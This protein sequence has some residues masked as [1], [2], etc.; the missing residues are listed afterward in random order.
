MR[1]TLI[2][3]C[4]VAATMAIAGSAGADV[5]SF[6]VNWGDIGAKTEAVVGI[7]VKVDSGS[8]SVQSITGAT[9]A[10]QNGGPWGLPIGWSQQTLMPTF[11][12]GTNPNASSSQY[13]FVRGG[14]GPTA[15][16]ADSYGGLG[17]DAPVGFTA[18]LA[19]DASYTPEVNDTI[20]TIWAFFRSNGA[21]SIQA[22]RTFTF[23]GTAWTGAT[24]GGTPWS[25]AD[26]GTFD[27]LSAAVVPAP[28]AIALLGLAGLSVRRRRN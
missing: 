13:G 16:T 28:G 8:A 14:G 10:G 25:Q 3:M 17:V 20:T 4:G 26:S 23:N 5:V 9:V 6:T 11:A 1:N 7:A 21:L 27:Q 24:T 2:G 15:A 18:T 12:A 22:T 19:L